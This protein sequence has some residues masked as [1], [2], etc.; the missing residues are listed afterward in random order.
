M[1]THQRRRIS[2]WKACGGFTIAEVALAMIV[3]AM[4]VMMFA[5]VFPMAVRGAQY[6]DNYAQA[7]MVAQHKMDQI[8]LA[9]YSRL[10]VTNA[11]G[12]PLTKMQNLAIID[13]PQPTGYPSTSNNVTTYSFSSTDGLVSSS[14]VQ[15]FFP[16]GSTGTITVSDYGKLYPASGVPQGTLA[17]VTVKIAWTGG[18]V[19]KGSYSLSALIAA[20]VNP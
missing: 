7:A 14:T 15:G 17:Y 8:R 2:R 18:G 4:M 9:G 12:T 6:S 13:K 16:P 19:S 5:A 11:E 3:F 1:P 10:L 20:V